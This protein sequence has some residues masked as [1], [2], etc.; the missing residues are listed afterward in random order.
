[1]CHLCLFFCQR[2]NLFLQKGIKNILTSTK[3]KLKSLKLHRIDKRFRMCGCFFWGVFFL[4][5]SFFPESHLESLHPSKD[6]LS[7]K[8][9]PPHFLH[10]RQMFHFCARRCYWQKSI[11]VLMV[12]CS[13]P[14]LVLRSKTWS[15]IFQVL[16]FLLNKTCL[17]EKKSGFNPYLSGN[18]G[19]FAYLNTLQC[20]RMKQ[21][22]ALS[23]VL[24]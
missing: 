7:S 20:W 24:Q 6:T 2:R 8:L 10:I 16:I 4:S 1:M 21:D 11:K 5:F 19:A 13:V 14:A 18:F 12:A 9:F 22:K 23:T 15:V 3:K 17:K